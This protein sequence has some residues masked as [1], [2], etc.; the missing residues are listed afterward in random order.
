M[1]NGVLVRPSLRDSQKCAECDYLESDLSDDQHDLEDQ[2][3]AR[4]RDRRG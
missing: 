4:R 3:L 2:D 1:E